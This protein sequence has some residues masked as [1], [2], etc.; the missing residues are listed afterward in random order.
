MPQE[1]STGRSLPLQTAS[2]DE[3]WG[4]QERFNARVLKS[5]IGVADRTLVFLGHAVFVANLLIC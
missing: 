1:S 2:L 5:E 4:Q 3:S